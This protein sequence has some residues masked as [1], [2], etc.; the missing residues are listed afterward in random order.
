MKL[1]HSL[2]MTTSAHSSIPPA[3]KTGCH[4]RP[5]IYCDP[6][7]DDR[8]SDPSLSISHRQLIRLIFI[9]AETASRFQR[10]AITVDPIQWLFAPRNLFEGK[11]AID[12]CRD[13]EAF[14]HAIILHGLSLGL[15]ASV[16]DIEPLIDRTTVDP[17]LLDDPLFA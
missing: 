9:A 10:D 14:T 2:G 7:D 15:D 6:L 11:A 16:H 4:G 13:R 3:E 5:V 12:A 17:V 8:D 1:V